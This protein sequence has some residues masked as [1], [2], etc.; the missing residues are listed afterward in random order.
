[1]CTLRC[2][3]S[4]N[5]SFRRLYHGHLHRDVL[6]PSEITHVVNVGWDVIQGLLCL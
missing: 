5:H 2:P 6:A 3:V 4:V 1:M